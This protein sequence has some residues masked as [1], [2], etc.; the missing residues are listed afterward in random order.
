MVKAMAKRKEKRT[1]VDGVVQTYE[2]GS[3]KDQN[4]GVR[5][6]SG[7]TAAGLSFDPAAML[8][9]DDSTSHTATL[10]DSHDR[11]TAGDLVQFPEEFDAYLPAKMENIDADGLAE[12][13]EVRSSQ[14]SSVN[15]GGVKGMDNGANLR[16]GTRALSEYAE[17]LDDGVAERVHMSV[18]AND[19]SDVVRSALLGNENVHS[20]AITECVN[21][22]IRRKR[23]E[24]RVGG[25]QGGHRDLDTQVFK[26]HVI[27]K[28]T[29]ETAESAFEHA[30]NLGKMKALR[31]N[32]P[33]SSDQIKQA[34]ANTTTS[35]RT[36]ESP[37]VIATM[38]SSAVN[39]LVASPQHTEIGER[40]S[41]GRGIFLVR[42]DETRY[43]VKKGGNEHGS[44]NHV[45]GGRFTSNDLVGQNDGGT[46]TGV[47]AVTAVLGSTDWIEADRG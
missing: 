3:D 28:M 20:G 22:A 23:L 13:I 8:A 45:G 5:G 17:S 10:V 12:L 44:I 38:R 29:P 34:A 35:K 21:T 46:R 47:T 37:E 26:P 2:V 18:L 41:I 14:I 43:A 27:N 25:V 11:F 15:D 33:I 42:T 24:A 9:A 31:N 16:K 32:A 6:K 7:S 30:G 39:A 36:S 19:P 1:R 4:A 40:V